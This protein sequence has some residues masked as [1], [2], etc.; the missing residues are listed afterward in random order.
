MEVEVNDGDTLRPANAVPL[1]IDG[2]HG[3]LERRE[4]GV[5]VVRCEDT[6]PREGVSRPARGGFETQASEVSRLGRR[7]FQTPDGGFS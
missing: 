6:K 5:G 3:E 2:G 1:F 7:G 4:D